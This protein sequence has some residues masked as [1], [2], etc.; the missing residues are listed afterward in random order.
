MRTNVHKACAPVSSSKPRTE[1]SRYRLKL[2]RKMPPIHALIRASTSPRCYVSKADF[3]IKYGL[4]K[5]LLKLL[6]QS[7]LS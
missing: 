5:R 7:F 6:F 2:P 1:I 4:V 3:A